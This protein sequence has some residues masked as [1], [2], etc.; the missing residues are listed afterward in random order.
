MPS[1]CRHDDPACAGPD[2]PF[3]CSGCARES[4]EEA[5]GE[6][7]HDYADCGQSAGRCDRC[8]RL[9]HQELTAFECG[10]CGSVV[11]PSCAHPQLAALAAEKRCL[12]CWAAKKILEGRHLPDCPNNH[13]GAV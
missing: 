7:V 12:T 2:Q 11:C 10:R 9:L 3:S 13:R 1:D 6:H 5:S 4:A 8:F